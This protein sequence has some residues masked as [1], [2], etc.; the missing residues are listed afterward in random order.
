MTNYSYK[1]SEKY[2]DLCMIYKN[3][4]GPGGLKLTE[5]LADK[6]KI[7]EGDKLLDV[8][9]NRGY[10]TCFLA[11]EYK[12][13]IIGVD[14]WGDAVEELRKNA[15]K[16]GVE[17][18]ILGLKAGVPNT[19]FA[20]FS[21]DKVYSTTTLEMLRGMHGKKGYKEAVEEIYRIL[22]PGGVFGLAEP[23]HNDVKIPEEIYPYI[24]KGDM[25]AP[26]TECFTTLEETV[27]VLKSVGFKIIEADKAPDAQRWWEEFAEY[28]PDASGQGGDAEVIEKDKGR[29]LTLGYVIARK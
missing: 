27:E 24:T 5:F 7:Q 15:E 23:M 18:N 1:R 20:D 14:P 22:K 19:N 29:W 26:W 17:A 10:Q 11:K 6:M 25:P 3:C 13:F 21:F 4:S 8:G 9:T 2:T 28:D 16:W 12:P